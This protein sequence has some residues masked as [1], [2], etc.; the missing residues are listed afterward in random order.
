MWGNHLKIRNI[1]LSPSLH[2]GI[3]VLSVVKLP[4]QAVSS[5]DG[6][7]ASLFSHCIYEITHYLILWIA[8]C[9]ASTHF[10]WEALGVATVQRNHFPR[11]DSKRWDKITQLYI[12]F[13]FPK[14]NL[15]MKED[16]LLEIHSKNEATV[17]TC[18]KCISDLHFLNIF[19]RFH[20]QGLS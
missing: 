10:W 16:I 20:R 4:H 5:S 11:A 18:S 14:T 6:K 1:I 13:L 3:F 2:S 9:S 15:M 12:T 19:H 17:I 7:A 8:N